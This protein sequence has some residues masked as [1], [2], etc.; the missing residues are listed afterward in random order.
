MKKYIYTLVAIMTLVLSSCGGKYVKPS[1]YYIGVQNGSDTQLAALKISASERGT[2][3]P[4]FQAWILT[5]TQYMAQGEVFNFKLRETMN[6]LVDCRIELLDT[7]GVVIVDTTLFLG[8]DLESS[9][10][11]MLKY[12]AD[13]T[14]ELKTIIKTL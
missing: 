6:I 12:K 5:E 10:T 1:S 13:K 3:T 8:G 2:E 4:L 9:I 7:L 11:Y 14:L